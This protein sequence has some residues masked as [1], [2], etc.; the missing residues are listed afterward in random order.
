[1]RWLN[2]IQLSDE[3]LN[4]ISTVIKTKKSCKLLVFGLGNDSVFYTY[5]NRGGTTIFLEDNKSWFQHVIKRSKRIVAY[6]V[7]YDTKRSDWRMLLKSPSLL[8]MALPNDVER[9]EWDVIL[10]D[11]PAGWNDQTPGRMKSIYL[12]SRLIKNSG[13]IFVH[14]CNR[15]I[16]DIYCNKYLKKENLKIEIKAKVGC[17]RHYHIDRSFHLTAFPLRSKAAGEF[18]R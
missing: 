10:V 3:Q 6:L 12:S 7:N 8:N 5:L 4:A 9:E 18:D 15:E 1:M 13:D 11:G 14:D 17:L 2:E 16:E